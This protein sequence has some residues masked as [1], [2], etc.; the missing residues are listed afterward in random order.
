MLYYN[1]HPMLSYLACV[2][3][4]TGREEVRQEEPHNALYTGQ[5]SAV[6]PCTLFQPRWYQLIT[7]KP[8]GL[9]PLAE[10]RQIITQDN[11]DP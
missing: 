10:S 3:H 1:I 11:Q 4:Q 2:V 8:A 5:L 7:V 6:D 9:M